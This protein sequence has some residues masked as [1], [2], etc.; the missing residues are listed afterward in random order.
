MNQGNVGDT[1]TPLAYLTT[2]FVK[3][4]GKFAPDPN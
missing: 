3:F 4:E 1:L 2:A